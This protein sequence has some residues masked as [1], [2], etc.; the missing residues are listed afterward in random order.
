MRPGNA[1]DATLG[2][3]PRTKLA[4]RDALKLCAGT[5]KRTRSGFICVWQ[6][7]AGNE[8]L[9]G[10]VLNVPPLHPILTIAGGA[11]T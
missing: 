2:L 6:N 8:Q 10:S 9:R 3:A 5:S 4:A 1:N 11:P 7:V